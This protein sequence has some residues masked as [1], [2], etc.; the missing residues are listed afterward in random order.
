M[1]FERCKE[2]LSSKETFYNPL[3]YKN[4]SDKEYDHALNV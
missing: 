4:N 1:D 3:T 2:K